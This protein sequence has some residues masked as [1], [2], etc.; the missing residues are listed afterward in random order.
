MTRLT[1]FTAPKP[2]S[3]ARIS[4]IQD[5][6]LASWSRL[7]DVEVLLM[8]DGPGLARAAREHGARQLREVRTNASGTP[9]ISSMIELARSHGQG[10]LLG[11]INADIIV[12]HDL[13]DAAAVASARL[14][15]FVLLGRRWDLDIDQPLDLS[16]GWE[17]RLR[18]QVQA[19]GRLHKPAGSDCFIFP[20][21]LYTD[22][23]GFAVG[24]AGWDNWMIFDARRRGIPVIDC[25]ASA[26]VVHQ[27]HHYDHLPGGAPHYALPE[28]DENIRLA[29]GTSA[30]RYTILDATHHLAGAKLIRPAFSR[31]R[32]M[33]GVE[34]LLRRALFFLPPAVKESIVRPK[35]WRKRWNRLIGGSRRPPDAID[36]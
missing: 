20:R 28:T 18:L 22:V 3:D 1:L 13:L 5:N 17:A 11:I 19:R 34:L 35:R 6:A 26:M 33:R 30:I 4:T 14:R 24:R 10:Q 27:N 8:G 12:M 32:F 9:L 25:T 36:D 31:D 29:G 7:E 2:F 16:N 21:E 15:Q 23:P